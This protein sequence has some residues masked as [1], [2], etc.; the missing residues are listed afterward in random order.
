[1]KRTHLDDLAAFAAIAEARSFTAAARKLGLSQSA[2]SHAMRSLEERLGVRLLARTTRSVATTEAGERLLNVIAPRFAEIES[3]LKALGE[4]RD[5]PSGTIRLTSSEHAATAY[6]W[7]AVH[8][9]TQAHPALNVEISID[10]ALT[11]IVAE[12]FDAGVRL[13]EAIAQDMIAVRISPDLRMAAVASPDYLAAQGVPRIPQDLASHRCINLRFRTGG[14][15]YAWE[16]E[17]D[18]RELSIRVEGQLVL[19]NVHL[20]RQAARDGAGIAYMIEDHVLAELAAGKLVRILEDWCA[21]FSGYHLYYPSA[22][23]PSAAFAL[24]VEELRWRG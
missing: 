9:L 16:F 7:P 22:R 8:R 12:R 15:L 4:L 11:D 6:L 2:L 24:L 18:G 13:G 14:N 5:Q 10:G 21:P 17:K 20:L 19:N 23:Q 1:M 3:E